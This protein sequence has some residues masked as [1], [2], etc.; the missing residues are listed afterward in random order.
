[1]LNRGTDETATPTVTPLRLAAVVV[2]MVLTVLASEWAGG[3]FLDRNGTN[4]GYVY[5]AHKWKVLGDLD[6]PI[7]WL[8]VG[9]S[10]GSQGFDPA[11]AEQLTGKRSINLATIGNFGLQDDLWMLE[12]YIER[13]GPPEKMV[14]IH[15]YDV[16]HRRFRPKLVGR[17]PR[18]WVTTEETAE[19]YDFDEEQRKEILLN[20]YVR[21]FAERKSLR[22]TIEFTWLKL[23]KDEEELEEIRRK[24]RKLPNEDPELTDSGFVRVCGALPK[25]V[26]RDARGHVR[27]LAKRRSRISKDNK[28]ALLA[29]AELAREHDFT[30]HIVPGPVYERLRL[31]KEFQ[32]YFDTEVRQLRKIVKDHPQ[33]YVSDEIRGFNG[34][35]LQN[36]DH[37]ACEHTETFTRWA[38]DQI[39]SADTK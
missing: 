13:F 23:T 38:V 34:D 12:E 36:V 24:D 4:L 9:D 26:K 3:R 29:I 25:S 1:M 32:K 5:I 37:L 17:I 22:K 6:E 2:I 20:R 33:V 16:W 15:V 14:L 19:R 28:E 10:S 27:T 31:K 11:V 7:D 18:R 39:Q 30:V 35:Q 21:L 8:V